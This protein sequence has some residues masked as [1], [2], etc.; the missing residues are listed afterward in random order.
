MLKTH[1]RKSSVGLSDH[2]FDCFDGFIPGWPSNTE[3]FTQ[4]TAVAWMAVLW[5]NE[6]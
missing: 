3:Q 2:F 6:A 1:Q 5:P 4:F